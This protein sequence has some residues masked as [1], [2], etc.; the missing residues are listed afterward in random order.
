[1]KAAKSESK[2]LQAKHWQGTIIEQS[3]LLKQGKKRK[4]ILLLN[5][6]N[7][8]M[9]GRWQPWCPTTTGTWQHRQEMWSMRQECQQ[10]TRP[11]KKEKQRS[12]H[13]S[14]N[15]KMQI[16]WM[17]SSRCDSFQRLLQS[18]R[19]KQAQSRSSIIGTISITRELG[20]SN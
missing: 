18:C 2:H 6:M 15:W 1:M 5:V 8:T 20:N 19:E 7:S 11:R 13:R 12:V 16:W 4:S 3:G 10:E 17:E 9:T 14:Q